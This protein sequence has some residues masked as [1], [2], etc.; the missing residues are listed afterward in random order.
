MP[1]RIAYALPGTALSGG[2]KVVLEQVLRLNRLPFFQAEAVAAGPFPDWFGTRPLPLIRSDPLSFDFSDYDILVTTFYTQ[3]ALQKRWAH[4]TLLHF[5]QGFEGDYAEEV[6]KAHHQPEIDAFYRNAPSIITV[7]DFLRKK[8]EPFGG[9]IRCIGQAIDHRVFYPGSSTMRVEES[10][11]IIGPF[12]LPFK[13]VRDALVV[14]REARSRRHQ[15]K[16]RRASPGNTREAESKYL[17]ADEYFIG[18]KPEQMAELYRSSSLV[19]Y[20]PDKEGFGLP[21]IEAMACGTPVVA[22]KIPPFQEICRDR[23][24]LFQQPDPLR[25]ADRVLD[26]SHRPDILQAMRNTG[27][28]VAGS[29]RYRTVLCKLAAFLLATH[30]RARLPYGN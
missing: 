17:A 8:L 27:I 26:L 13:G 19:L 1:I 20:L 6:G 4:K 15:L 7:N 14:A 11:L 28:R 25:L 9:K 24:P 12:D 21:L 16:V 29:Y 10:I 2:V 18:L 3:G 22:R 23:Y 30:G 5:C